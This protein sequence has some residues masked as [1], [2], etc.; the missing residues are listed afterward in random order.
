MKQYRIIN[1]EEPM[2]NG[3]PCNALTCALV[4]ADGSL[5]TTE[6]IRIQGKGP[7]DDSRGHTGDTLSIDL[8][9]GSA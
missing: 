9:P 4:N 6:I 3:Q 5:S 8:V 7:L 2:V 1:R